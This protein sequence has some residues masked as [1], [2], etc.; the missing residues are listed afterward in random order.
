MTAPV[1]PPIPA[2]PTEDVTPASA[3][4]SPAIPAGLGPDELEEIDKDRKSVV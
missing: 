2:A 3:L 4:A 1:Q